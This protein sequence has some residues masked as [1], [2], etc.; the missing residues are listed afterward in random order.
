MA[1]PKQE[2]P[3][4]LGA[5][6]TQECW[7]S[8]NSAVKASRPNSIREEKSNK[9]RGRLRM[10]LDLRE[11]RNRRKRVISRSAESNRQS[12]TKKKNAKDS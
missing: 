8:T 3:R 11:R 1:A 10:L 5:L 12:T 4:F 6:C 7:I 2:E 9:S